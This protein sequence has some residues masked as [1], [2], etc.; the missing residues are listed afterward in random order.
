MIPSA[1]YRVLIVPPSPRDRFLLGRSEI[2]MKH[3]N[4]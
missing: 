2:L 4:L 3:V 1:A